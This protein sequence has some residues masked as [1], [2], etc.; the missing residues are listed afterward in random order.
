MSPIL[1]RRSAAAA[2]YSP[3]AGITPDDQGYDACDD[4]AFPTSMWVFIVSVAALAMYNALELVVMVFLTFRRYHG[5]YFYS[6]LVSGLAIIPYS[7]GFLL[8]LLSVTTGKARW[9]AVTLITVGWWPMVTGQAVVLW[10]RLHLIVVG[11]KG[12]RVIRWTK[13][14]ILINAI[15]LHLPTTGESR[16]DGKFGDVSN[17]TNL[18]IS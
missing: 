14:M 12:E 9:F 17:V 8:D 16:L 3:G 4:Q 13:W 15:V 11:G 2:W 18:P 10:S 7:L 5:L 1:L 6:L